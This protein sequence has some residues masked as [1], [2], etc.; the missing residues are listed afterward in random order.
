VNTTLSEKSI[1]HALWVCDKAVQ[2]NQL[3]H[4]DASFE[5]LAVDWNNAANETALDCGLNFDEW[6]DG[7]YAVWCLKASGLE[8]AQENRRIFREHIAALNL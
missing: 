8:I 2:F 3:A 6:N 5:Q 1:A 4:R 7:A